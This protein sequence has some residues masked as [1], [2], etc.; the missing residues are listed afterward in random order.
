MADSAL[1]EAQHILWG[2][3][4]VVSA[5][6]ILLS[7]VDVSGN[8]IRT[9]DRDVKDRPSLNRW[10]YTC[11]SSPDDC[12]ACGED[13]RVFYTSPGGSV[14]VLP[15]IWLSFAFAMWSG[16]C[17]L[18][19]FCLIRCGGRDVHDQYV[20]AVA[21]RVYD[22]AVSASLMIAV[23]NAL[24]GA[25]TIVGV[26]V[27]PPL[28]AVVVILG[29]TAE[30]WFDRGDHRKL[31]VWPSVLFFCASGLYLVAWAPAFQ[32]LMLS[33]DSS[34]V[35]CAGETPSLVWIFVIL[36][37]LVFSTFPVVWLWYNWP[38]FREYSFDA[39]EEAYNVCS[40]VAKVTLHS[41]IAIS[42]FAQRKVLAPSRADATEPTDMGDTWKPF[43]AVVGA[44]VGV[45]GLN[46]VLKKWFERDTRVVRIQ[47]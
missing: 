33:T 12:R 26:Y 45:V 8:D 6:T 32:A 28:M 4:H 5:V 7:A 37:F 36:M 27:A 25:S 11:A 42:I 9:F 47:M 46:A 10:L 15:V 22:Y 1:S 13:D 3:I 31:G 38:S 43:V 40:C 19:S 2:A 41:F 29:G 24:F 23:L 34:S 16:A 20:G 21:V 30:Y 18:A 39:R 44:S 35:E 14:G 17:H